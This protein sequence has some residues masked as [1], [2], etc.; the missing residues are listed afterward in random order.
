[1]NSNTV[2]KV[3]EAFVVK[4]QIMKRGQI[5][6]VTESEARLLLSLGKAEL[7]TAADEPQ[8]EPEPDPATETDDQENSIK[9]EK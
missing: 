1:M 6:E 4:G 9:G 2:L 7:A 8:G 5:V 3:T